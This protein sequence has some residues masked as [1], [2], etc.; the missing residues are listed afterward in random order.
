[1]ELKDEITTGGQNNRVDVLGIRF[2]DISIDQA[3]LRALE[4]MKRS[5]CRSGS[6]LYDRVSGEKEYVVTPNP[7]IVW[8][9]RRNELLRAALCGASLVL[10]DG[11]GIVYGARILG[12]PLRNGRVPGIEFASSLFEKMAEN[13]GTVFLLGAEPGIAETAGQNLS[14]K[15]PGLIIAGTADGYFTDSGQ[16]IGHINTAGPDLLL[17]C[18]GAPK[19]EIWMAENLE[20]LNIGMCAGLG[21]ALDV[22]AGKVKRAPLFFRRL[23]LEWLYRIIREPRRIKRAM[24]LPLFLF[25]VIFRRLSRKGRTRPTA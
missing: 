10:P 22:F 23:G 8:M 1:M 16:I 13:G 4:V 14:E 21:G 18:L 11:I 24:K 7:E 17:V 6:G 20:S 3:V 25:V 19:Q 9:A 2:D 15:H 12:S 5:G